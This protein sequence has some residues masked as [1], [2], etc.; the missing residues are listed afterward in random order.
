[1]YIRNY[2][3]EHFNL[4]HS[5]NICNIIAARTE[6]WTSLRMKKEK[7]TAFQTSEC[8]TKKSIM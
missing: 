5:T 6:R 2:S 7:E 3:I 4:R 8:P 1:M